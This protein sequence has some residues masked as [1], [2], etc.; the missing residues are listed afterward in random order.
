[1]SL[2]ILAP[3]HTE[4]LKPPCSQVSVEVTFGVD[5]D[6]VLILS[7]L[8]FQYNFS[9]SLK[10]VE[11]TLGVDVDVK[12]LRLRLQ[13]NKKSHILL[14]LDNIDLFCNCYRRILDTTNKLVVRKLDLE[15]H[16]YESVIVGRPPSVPLLFVP[17]ESCR[18]G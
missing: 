16:I 6:L 10:P 2:Y 15:T 18:I 17:Q 7:V 14:T 12:L 13:I 3:L 8:Y 11:V 1:M 9:S 5:V 4:I